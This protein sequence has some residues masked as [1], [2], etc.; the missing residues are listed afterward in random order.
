MND[1]DAK[2][3]EARVALSGLKTFT[4]KY[5]VEYWCEIAIQCESEEQLES[6]IDFCEVTDRIKEFTG[7]DPYES[8]E[9]G[10]ETTESPDIYHEELLELMGEDEDED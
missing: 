8:W 3:D 5:K 9:I 7:D 6:A 4:V 1:K 2:V 10:E